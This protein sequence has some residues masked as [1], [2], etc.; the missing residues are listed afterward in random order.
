MTEPELLLDNPAARLYDI[1]RR[2]K[3]SNSTGT[4]LSSLAGSLS[5]NP[6]DAIGVSNAFTH[7]MGL[8]NDTDLA[9]EQL[10]GYKYKRYQKM[11]ER[12]K[13]AFQDVD[14]QQKWPELL[15][16]LNNETFL[17]LKSCAEVLSGTEAHLDRD[18][19]KELQSEV[20][21]LIEKVIES[22]E[23]GK[24]IRAVIYEKLQEIDKAIRDYRFYGAAGIRRAFESSLGAALIN[25]EQIQEQKENKLVKEFFKVLVKIDSVLSPF[26]K[27][28]QLIPPGMIQFLLKSGDSDS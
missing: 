8:I 27:V 13:T 14:Y 19:L 9:I 2:I 21:S 24:E 20:N 11:I 28:K 22:D 23:L 12:I 3:Q 1:L 26:V 6:D 16:Y 4:V 10:E 17:S 25:Q 15:K 5:V 7:L 18:A